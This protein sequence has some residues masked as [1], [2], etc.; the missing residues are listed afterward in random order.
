MRG[1]AL[2]RFLAWPGDPQRCP[3]STFPSAE[4]SG[5]LSPAGTKWAQERRR[6]ERARDGRGV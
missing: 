4:G 6:L 2:G 3:R 1:K 5:H